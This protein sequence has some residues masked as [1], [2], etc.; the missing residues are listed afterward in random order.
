[1]TTPKAKR[2]LVGKVQGSSRRPKGTVP[3]GRENGD[4][5]P[6]GIV[7]DGAVHPLEGQPPPAT[8]KGWGRVPGS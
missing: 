5:L 4:G 8:T 6:Y 3:I 1:M 2:K 7:I